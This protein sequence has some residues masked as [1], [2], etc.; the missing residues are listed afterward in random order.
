MADDDKS[1]GANLS[2][3]VRLEQV[4][5]SRWDPAKLSKFMQ[6]SSSKGTQL[7]VSQRGRFEK[8]LGVDLGGVRIY[9]GELAEEITRAHGAE[10]LTV[11]DTGIILMRQST[12]F[13][14]GSAAHTALLAHELTHVAQARPDAVARKS[15]SAQQA[16]VE[17]SEQEAE[18]HEAEVLAEEL[19]MPELAPSEKEKDET[20]KG[21][22][23]KILALVLEMIEEDRLIS[24]QRT[25]SRTMPLF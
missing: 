2:P 6:R 25:G 18:H 23:D 11:G 15:T 21:K 5:S 8:R 20:K 10:A 22:K 4:L 17:E 7:D 14:P 12:K 13:T 19:K 1:D 9:S 16:Q 24:E 3:E